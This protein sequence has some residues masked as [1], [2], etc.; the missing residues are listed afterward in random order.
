ME[1]SKA[2]ALAVPNDEAL[3]I[4]DEVG[5]FQEIRSVLAKPADGGDGKKIIRGVGNSRS[6][7]RLTSYFFG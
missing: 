3:A 6:A 2:F 4:R 1:L 7:N 5:F